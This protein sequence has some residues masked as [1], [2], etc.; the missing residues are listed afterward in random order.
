MGGKREKREIEEKQKGEGS[1]G[2]RK[3][4]KRDGRCE[5]AKHKRH[6]E[7]RAPR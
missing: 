3:K 6:L 2:G 7:G 4:E 5:A 1:G